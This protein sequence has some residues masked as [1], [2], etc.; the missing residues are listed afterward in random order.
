LRLSH[1]FK[2]IRGAGPQVQDAIHYRDEKHERDVGPGQEDPQYQTAADKV[3]QLPE[4]VFIVR[5]DPGPPLPER[6]RGQPHRVQQEQYRK[7]TVEHP[8]PQVAQ[9]VERPPPAIDF[10]L[11]NQTRLEW[12]RISALAKMFENTASV[13][14]NPI[15]SL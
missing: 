8:A 15:G 2:I 6:Y 5:A 3:I 9:R 7:I 4:D 10:N 13:C 12:V 11:T 14:Y 1:G